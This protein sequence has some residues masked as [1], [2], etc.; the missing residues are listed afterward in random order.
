MRKNQMIDLLR[1]QYPDMKWFKKCLVRFRIK[2]TTRM[3]LSN[4]QIELAEQDINV[5]NQLVEQCKKRWPK[6][7]GLTEKKC[8]EVLDKA[9]EFTGREDKTTVYN[10]ILFCIDLFSNSQH[11]YSSG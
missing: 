11:K 3:L 10:D 4:E 1:S 2:W 9:P 6:I 8:N 7:Y 5:K